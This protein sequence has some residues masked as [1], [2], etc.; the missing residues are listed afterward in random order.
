MTN[1]VCAARLML[2]V[3]LWALLAGVDTVAAQQDDT[4]DC[5][6]G[7][8]TVVK[9]TGDQQYKQY[10]PAKWA[11][12]TVFDA[13]T[14]TWLQ[15]VQPT[16]VLDYPVILGAK[17]NETPWASMCFLGGTIKGTNNLDATWCKMKTPNNAALSF[18]ALNSTIDGVRIH[19][20][21][22]GVRPV[23]G[24]GFVV[25]N[26]WMS[27]IRDDAVENDNMA[28][29]TI[30]D[31]LIDGAYVGFSCSNADVTAD[32]SANVVRIQ[33]C[34]VRLEAQPGPRQV[35]GACPADQSGH[36]GFFKWSGFNSSGNLSIAPQIELHD[37]IF[38]TD[39]NIVPSS[40]DMGLPPGR[41]KACSNN[42]V[43]WTGQGTYPG[44]L[45]LDRF[46]S[47]FTVV[48]NVSIWTDAKQDWINRHP[49]VPRL[50]G[51]PG[52]D[53]T[54]L[55]EPAPPPTGRKAGKGHASVTRGELYALD[56]RLVK[57]LDSGELSAA[58][59]MPAGAYVLRLHGE[60]CVQ[61]ARFLAAAVR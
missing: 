52:P 25:K 15:Q 6:T 22:D 7:A 8:A 61:T 37:N 60:G 36:A 54:S 29:G 46:P 27:Y 30:D 53:V 2:P 20:T 3:V 39:G 40:V 31:C 32:A 47:G 51:D 41:L 1:R 12:G 55:V 13:R 18:G 48:T 38:Y 50:A 11:A 45:E 16:L 59:T 23:K 58:G 9:I 34:L 57:R 49:T 5:L 44:D 28:A 35:G 19:N 24:D 56:G 43:V 10:R 33:N 17:W 21:G 26:C 4:Y 14:A 42:I